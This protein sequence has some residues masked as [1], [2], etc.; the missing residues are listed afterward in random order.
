MRIYS[1]SKDKINNSYLKI[2]NL[3][4]IG[5]TIQNA[6]KS[7]NITRSLLYRHLTKEQKKELRFYKTTTLTYACPSQ[8]SGHYL[9]KDFMTFDYDDDFE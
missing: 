9:M 6:C 8:G 5:V 1:D 4:K 3:V 7:L 2:L